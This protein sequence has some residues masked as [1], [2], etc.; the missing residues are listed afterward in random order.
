MAAGTYGDI[1]ALGWDKALAKHKPDES[2]LRGS[3][4][5]DL[6]TA[7][8]SLSDVDP[9]TLQE[10]LSAMRRIAAEV[11]GIDL[12]AS[13]FATRSAAK[14]EWLEK[15]DKTP[16]D[17]ITPSGVEAWKLGYVA[18]NSQDEK[19]ARKAR[20][21]VNSLLR[22]A[23]SLFTKR[24]M[25][26]L[27]DRVTLPDKLPF[28]DVEMFPRQSMRYAGG[29][30]IKKLLLDAK[31]ELGDDPKR[32]EEWKALILTLFVGLRRNEADKYLWTSFDFDKCFAR[33]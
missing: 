28:A 11:R 16:I 26:F 8:E 31:K 15:V 29:I 3:S 14:E 27:P 17:K 7:V 33:V 6:I 12:P 1:V 22:K 10:N 20:N 19:Q 2:P 25:K 30:D 32:V 9:A 5:G 18:A 23:K 13:R 4:L 21:T 24:L